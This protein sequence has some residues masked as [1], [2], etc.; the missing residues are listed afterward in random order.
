MTVAGM[1]KIESVSV[2]NNVLLTVSIMV[3][4]VVIL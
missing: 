1:T 3:G 2:Q 4:L